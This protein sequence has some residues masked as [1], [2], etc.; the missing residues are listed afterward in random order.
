MEQLSNQALEK[1]IEVQ[2]QQI[3]LLEEINKR[4]MA[5]IKKQL[6]GENV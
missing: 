4:L 1:L 6:E 3:A 5:I 2:M